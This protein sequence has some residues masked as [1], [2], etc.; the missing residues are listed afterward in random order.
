MTRVATARVILLIVHLHYAK[1]HDPEP[2]A[3][4]YHGQH[5]DTVVE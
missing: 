2:F 3:T 1:P 5:Q 4:G